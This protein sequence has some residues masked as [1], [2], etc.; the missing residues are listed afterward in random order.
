MQETP[1]I[2]SGVR[3]ERGQAADRRGTAMRDKEQDGRRPA[4]LCVL[5]GWG[6]S[7]AEADNAIVAG[8]APAFARL[9]RACPHALVATSGVDVGLPSGQMGN[10]EVGH[11][12]LG[13]GRILMQDICRVDAAIADGSIHTNPA[14]GGLIGRLR[15]SGGTCHLMGLISP[16]GV[17]SHQDHV[18][19]LA[20]IVDA[21]GIPVAIHGFLDGRDT[22]P[23]SAAEHVAYFQ[24]QLAGLARTRIATLCGRYYAM[25]RDQRWDRTE[26]AYDLL[27]AGSGAATADPVA[28]VR[29]SYGAGVTDEFVEPA[30]MGGYAGMEDGDGILTANFRADRVRQILLAL[31]QD[32]FEGFARSR[33]AAFATAVGLTEYSSTHNALMTT[34]FPPERLENILGR[35]VSDAGMCQL[36]IAET[37]KYAHVTYFFN[38]GEETPFVGEKRVLIPSPKVA[39][40]DEQPEMSAREVT[41]RLVT[42]IGSGRHDLI[43]V[44][45]ANAD[46][47]GHTGK[48]GAAVHAIRAVDEC[49]ERLVR[50]VESAGGVLLITADHGNAESMRD[51][52][53]GEPHTAHTINPVPA[54]LVNAPDVVSGLRAGRLSDIAPTL[55]DLMGMESPPEMTG[56]SL[57]IRRDAARIVSG[58]PAPA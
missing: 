19:E 20:S 35:V 17:H 33:R 34:M 39:T 32:D 27:V 16:G 30:V 12:T 52:E 22:P 53:T 49:L 3:R 11:I 37:E 5:D 10:S 42:E 15:R 25:D 40:Y 26:R 24:G 51:H 14:L 46:M 9:W 4:V 57:L 55:L 56:T 1:I 8:N 48:L 38:G 31:L 43:V 45:Y 41:D 13:A 50:A 18:A 21:H 6:H 29:A 44:N 54:V 47:V 36:R 23:S 2:V 28:A 58:R 7:E